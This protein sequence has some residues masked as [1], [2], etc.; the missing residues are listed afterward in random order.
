MQKKSNK[1]AIKEIS[2]TVNAKNNV[3]IQLNNQLGY[4]AQ[5]L[6]MVK[7][8]NFSGN[9]DNQAEF[10]DAKVNIDALNQ[11]DYIREK[12]FEIHDEVLKSAELRLNEE[13]LD[14][15]IGTALLEEKIDQNLKIYGI[16]ISSEMIRKAKEKELNIEL[17]KGSFTNIPYEASRFD[18]IISC[19]AFHH[20]SDSEKIEA[21]YEMSRVLKKSGKIIIADF[22]CF[23]E[24][25]RLDLIEK[26]KEENRMDM[27]EEMD[28][29]NFTHIEKFLKEI[30]PIGFKSEFRQLSTISWILSLF[31]EL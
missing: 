16:D 9:H 12:Y 26:F 18:K 22:M 11:F 24:L 14:I 5:Y 27:I 31:K 19:F 6:K 8:I 23:D 2:T 7:K 13:V 21:I 29:E 20:L 10:Y 30:E 28:D 15:G 1:R 4:E 25:Q 17:K 3:M